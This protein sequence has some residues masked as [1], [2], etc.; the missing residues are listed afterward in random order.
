MYS[1]PKGP[2]KIVASAR[3]GPPRQLDI[4]G[5]DSRDKSTKLLKSTGD[6]E[7]EM[8]NPKPTFQSRKVNRWRPPTSPSYEPALQ[9]N[10]MQMVNLLNRQWKKVQDSIER[11]KDG[12]ELMY[13]TYIEPRSNKSIADFKPFDLDNFWGGQ[14]LKNAL[15]KSQS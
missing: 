4:E 11:R 7:V 2:S 1:L 12:S 10:H 5:Y 14:T 3:R 9:E 8:S 6:G 15:G 13:E